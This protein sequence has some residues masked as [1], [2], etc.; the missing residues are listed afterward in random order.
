MRRSSNSSFPL[1]AGF[2]KLFSGGK[3]AQ[4]CDFGVWIQLER[5][6]NRFQMMLLDIAVVE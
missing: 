3:D 1:H 5:P 4:E 6:I 2:H